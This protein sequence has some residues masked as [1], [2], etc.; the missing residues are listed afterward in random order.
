MFRTLV[1][2]ALMASVI[3]ACGDDNDEPNTQA[4][5]QSASDEASPSSATQTSGGSGEPWTAERAQ[6]LLET[7]L[8]TPADVSS[9][10]TV[11]SDT[12]ADNAQAA[13][14]DPANAAS[15]ERC[16]RLLGR[17]LVLSP[18]DVVER[19][20]GGETVSYFSQAT[21]YATAGGAADCAAEA[22]A[23]FSSCAELA[24]AFGSI[25][26]DPTAV[27]CVPF[28]YAQVG[29]GSFATTLSGKISAAGT[30]VDLTIRIVAWLQDNV[31][32]VVGMAAAF[33]PNTAELEPLVELVSQRLSDAQ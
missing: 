9:V 13:T 4:P 15:F 27:S 7:A 10:W 11:M 20:I 19:Y 23:R 14:Q 1:I 30:I 18:P 3:S 22:A 17:T 24:K 28:E 29:Q 2:L 16:G 21:V 26:I 31:T 6:A 32:V 33:D 25:F 5:T 12:T 8:V